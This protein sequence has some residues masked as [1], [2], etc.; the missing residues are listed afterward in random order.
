MERAIFTIK[1]IRPDGSVSLRPADD[2]ETL[3]PQNINTPYGDEA[4]VIGVT[5]RLDSAIS[6][7]ADT[8]RV[9]VMNAQGKTVDRY[10][11]PQ[12]DEPDKV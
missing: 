8:G 7:Q 12:I 4:A 2:V 10:F 6:M 9:Y 11:L 5:G 3:V 1:H